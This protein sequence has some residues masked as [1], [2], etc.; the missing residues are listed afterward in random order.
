MNNYNYR[1]K[2]FKNIYSDSGIYKIKITDSDN[3]THYLDITATE[4]EQIKNILLDYRIK[5]V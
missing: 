5:T 2:Q 4:F 3:F 1:V